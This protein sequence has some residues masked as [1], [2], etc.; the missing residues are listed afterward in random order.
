MQSPAPLLHGALEE[1]LRSVN[2]GDRSVVLE[3][4]PLDEA[5]AATLAPI[6]ETT[7]LLAALVKLRAVPA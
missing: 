1:T 7:L 3:T 5:T 4:E 6:L 2:A